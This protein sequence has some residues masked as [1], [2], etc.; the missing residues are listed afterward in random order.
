MSIL[1]D[2]LN[3]VTMY[4]LVL[5]VLAALVGLAVVLAFCGL[6]PYSPAAILFSTTVLVGVSIATQSICARVYAATPNSESAYIT[7]LILALLITPVLPSS[8][9]GTGFLALAALWATASKYLIAFRKKHL[10][11]P[12]ALGVALLPLFGHEAASWWAGGTL[13]LL[14]PIILGGI[15][16]A[17]KIR[18]FDLMIAFIVSAIASVVVA[19]GW[20]SWSLVQGL[21]LHTPLLFFAGIM[22]TEP[23]TLPP[24][25]DGRLIYGAL[26]GILLAPTTQI[27]SLSFSP[28]LALLVGNLFT[29]AL[30]PMG[31]V[32]LTLV[33]RR[34]LAYDQYE[35][36]FKPERPLAFKPGQYLEWT[37]AHARPD[38]RGIR[39]YFTIASSPTE[40]LIQLGV[41][42]TSSPST[43]KRAL[44]ILRE[45]DVISVS[46][47]SGDFVLPVDPTK[48]LVW[49]AGGIGITPFRSMA[50]YLADTHDT[51]TITLL[52]S[53]KHSRD[54]AYREFF[55]SVQTT[56]GLRPVYITTDESGADTSTKP[57]PIDATLIARE[58]PDY[59]DRYF[60]LSG[61][62]GMVE[63]FKKTLRKMGV[64]HTRIKTD[65]FPGFA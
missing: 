53:V 41:K 12:A 11:N 56:I 8:A 27:G 51:R 29:F 61:P 26:V 32:A 14:P 6:I 20:E 19:H 59:R 17:R 18:R 33:E 49:I 10:F 45:G 9:A 44:A 5:Y 22:L 57:G 2:L 30:S 24:T 52:Y 35:Y 58:V 36:L 47:L 43:F 62:Y 55:D 3:R 21:V 64:P 25:R 39:R 31:R 63:T 23:L 7:A 37:A 15:L 38:T 50:A 65:Y 48:R 28:E 40:P 16:V 42:H 60:Y 54:L 34:P 13:A 1:D 46:N 4:R